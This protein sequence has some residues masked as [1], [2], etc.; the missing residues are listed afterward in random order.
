M[1]TYE[2]NYSKT[3][4]FAGILFKNIYFINETSKTLSN[5]GLIHI[6][7]LNLLTSSGEAVDIHNIST[8]KKKRSYMPEIYKTIIFFLTRKQ[9]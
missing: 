8:G 9:P 6:Q 7:N 3:V 2:K 1:K 4:F 5:P